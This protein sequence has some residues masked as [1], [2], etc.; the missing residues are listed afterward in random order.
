MSSSS[1]LSIQFCGAARTV[2]G[3]MYFLEYTQASGR[4]FRFLVDA[5]MFQVGQDVSLFKMNS[6]LLFEPQKLDAVILTHCHLDHC[7]RLPFLVK[8]GF[9]GRIYSTPASQELTAIVLM[10]A[11]KQQD[12]NGR[13]PGYHFEELGLQAGD[14][15]A[16]LNPDWFV[17]RQP[18]LEV[19]LYTTNDV[20][21]TMSRFKTYDYHQEFEIAD[22]LWVEYRDAGHILGSANVVL[23]HKDSYG[24]P[25][26]QMIFSGDLGNPN[27]PIIEDPEMHYDLPHLTHIVVESTY[28]DRNHPKLEPKQR[29]KDIIKATTKRGGKLLVPSFS[30]E[31]AQEVIYYIAELMRD[32]EIQQMPIYLDSPMAT[33]V[34]EVC[35]DHPELY[36]MELRE[37]IAQKANPLIYKQLKILSTIGDSKA[38]NDRPGSHILIAGSGMLNGGRILKHLLHEGGNPDNTLLFVGYQASGT[39]GR[40]ILDLWK[41]N[42]PIIVQVEYHQMEIK[43]QI[44]VINEFSAH[45]DQRMLRDWISKLI[46][47]SDL[48]TGN[49][50]S[51]GSQSRPP[52]TVF[53]THGEAN[54]SNT[55]ASELVQQ[56]RSNVQTHWPHFGEKVQIW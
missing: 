53:I 40:Q 35:L 22:G 3:S 26:R 33:R 46:L 38:I 7:G 39:L 16:G 6:T 14:I 5:G 28:G 34:L 1:S 20:E 23:T 49:N 55:L 8:R 47:N 10:D 54:A 30:V 50:F 42:Q 15:D 37:K 17:P 45:A 32:N 18:E 12:G 29:L 13:D 2:T 4:V 48:H 56:H 51:T 41:A 43:A 9:G 11:A 52:V 25:L 27:K 21:L 44:A 31:R 19:S 36:D 24:N